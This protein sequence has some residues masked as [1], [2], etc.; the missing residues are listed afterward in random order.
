MRGLKENAL[1]VQQV[2]IA[3]KLQSLLLDVNLVLIALKDR[4]ISKHAKVDIIAMKTQICSKKYV[5]QITDAQEVLLILFSA[6]IDYYVKKDRKS[7]Y[8]AV[9][10]F[11]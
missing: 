8:S 9:L 3:L 11:I 5:P 2:I 7:D 6:K 4:L 10:V 1:H